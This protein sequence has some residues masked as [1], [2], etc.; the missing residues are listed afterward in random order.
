MLVY[1]VN[2]TSAECMNKHSKT[3]ISI[4]QTDKKSIYKWEE[5]CEGDFQIE[6][7]GTC[8]QHLLK[9]FFP[10]LFFLYKLLFSL[11]C[12]SQS[13]FPSSHG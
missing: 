5:K 6:D 7:V 3:Y 1:D 4:Y 11:S 9:L 13:L 8:L 10:F 2:K 12:F